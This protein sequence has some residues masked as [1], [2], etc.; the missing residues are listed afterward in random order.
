M[1]KTITLRIE[2]P[3][4]EIL[5]KAALGE[6]RTISNFIENAAIQYLTNEFYATDQEME[7]ILT[8]KKLVSSLKKGIKQAKEGKYKI[9]S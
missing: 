5:K 6:R 7:G 9:V 3:I 2:E 4:Y 1:T 8:D